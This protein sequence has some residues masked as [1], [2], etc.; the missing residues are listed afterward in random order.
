MRQTLKVGITMLVVAALAMSGIALAQTTDDTT[1]TDAVVVE[2]LP[3]YG[4]IQD[5][6]TPLVED[7]TLT[8][9]QAD[10]VAE[11]LAQELPGRG[12]RGPRFQAIRSVA[13][14]FEMTPL[15][16]HEALADYDSLAA[17]AAANGS[18]A[19]ELISYLVDQAEER[20]AEAVDNGRITEDEAAE[21]AANLED[22]ITDLV[23]GEIP[24]RPIGGHGPRFGRRGNGADA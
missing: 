22:H 2:D 19:D 11:T 5:A 9:A 1:S 10:A 24:E 4:R 12:P 6:L 16:L 20:L 14:F 13:D 7:G 17:F 23:N 8:Q 3:V 18:S 21:I 15:E